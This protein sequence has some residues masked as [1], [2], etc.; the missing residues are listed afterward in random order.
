MPP[1]QLQ[2]SLETQEWIKSSLWLSLSL[3]PLPAANCT[4]QLALPRALFTQH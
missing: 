1:V 4:Q 3:V 2:G